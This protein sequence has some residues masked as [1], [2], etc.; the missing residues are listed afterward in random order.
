[1]TVYRSRTV[2]PFGAR[3]PQPGVREIVDSGPPAGA[4][5][6][7]FRDG[8]GRIWVPT[9]HG[10]ADYEDGRFVPV[11]ALPDLMVH[12]IAEARAGDL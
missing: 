6:S 11:R 12:P 3:T 9:C 1:M 8:R 10:I 4:P 7:L 2:S 5:Q